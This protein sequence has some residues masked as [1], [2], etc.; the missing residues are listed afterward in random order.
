MNLTTN[1]TFSKGVEFWAPKLLEVISDVKFSIN[2]INPDINE[3][4]MCGANTKKQLANIEYYLNIRKQLGNTSTVTL[5]CTFM[6]SNLYELKNI[7]LWGIEHGVDRI[8][9]HHLWKTS[10]SLD[11]EMLRTKENAPLWNAV[12]EECHK[13]ADGRIRLENFTPVDLNEPDLDSSDTFCQFLGKELWIEYDG[14]YQICCCPDEVRRE[15]G[16]FGNVTELSP[17]EMWNGRKYRDFIANW[18]ESEN[19]KKCNMRRKRS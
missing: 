12:C 7:I 1:G 19:C 18:G 9:G 14:S 5:Q 17:L 10:D 16:E 2:G 13:T 11:N 4:I 3:K 8:K 6:K 15:F